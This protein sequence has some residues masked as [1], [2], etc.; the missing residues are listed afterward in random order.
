MCTWCEL[1]AADSHGRRLI[2]IGGWSGDEYIV[3]FDRE[4]RW[5]RWSAC[6]FAI[7]AGR[8]YAGEALLP[9]S[10]PLPFFAYPFLVAT[11]LSWAWVVLRGQP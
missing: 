10:S 9:T 1:R 7:T 8:L 5:G 3:L 2:V 4:E 11:L 6:P